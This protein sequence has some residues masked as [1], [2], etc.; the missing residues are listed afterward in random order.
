MS[1][2]P[3]RAGP[4]GWPWATCS[5]R[6]ASTTWRS[7]TRTSSTSTARCSRAS[8]CR[9]SI[10]IVD[11]DF[12]KAYYARY[13]DRSAR[14][15]DAAVPLAAAGG[16]HAPRSATIRTS[17]TCRR[18]ATPCPASSPCSATWPRG[19]GCRRTGA[20]RSFACSRRSG[21]ARRSES[22]RSRSPE[23]YEHKHQEL[24]GDDPTRGLN[25]MARDVGH[26]PAPDAGGGGRGAVG[27]PAPEPARGLSAR[28][29]GL[30]WP[31][32]TRWPPSMAST[33][34]RHEEEMNVQTF[35]SALRGAI[36]EFRR[37]PLGPPLVPNWARVWA[38]V[39]DAGPRLMSAVADGP[40]DAHVFLAP[41]TRDR[42]DDQLT[43]RAHPLPAQRSGG[44]PRVPAAPASLGSSSDVHAEPTRSS[45]L[46]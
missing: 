35:A 37:D 24:S 19:C 43:T 25:R 2:R 22:A 45:P 9:H 31:T 27:R 17:A 32:A 13:S 5:P 7:S 44:W 33:Y 40:V 34:D 26:A 16:V 6:N 14:P 23:R 18:S 38:G 42:V 21:T 20:S 10:P 3:E 11:F 8:S 12:V 39:H 46:A 15:R 4:A 36:E 41:G 1:A 28:G 29:R 30:R